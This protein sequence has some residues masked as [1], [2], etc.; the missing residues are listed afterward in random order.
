MRRIVPADEARQNRTR[1]PNG[2]DRGETENP[3]KFH[4]AGARPKETSNMKGLCPEC[5]GEVNIPDDAQTGE[6]LV[7]PDC[8][9]ELELT[10]V[11]PAQLK[12]APK[13]AE[14]WGE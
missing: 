10:G 4:G 9:V 13:E 6:I 7:C 8:G 11:D 12:L 2:T 1:R 3:E 14:D 5:E